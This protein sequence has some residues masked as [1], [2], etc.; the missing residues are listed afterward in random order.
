MMRKLLLSLAACMPV[1]TAFSQNGLWSTVSKN[2]LQTYLNGRAAAS[3]LPA[4][5]ELIK[6]NRSLLQQ[7]QQQAPL[8]K[9]GQ[10]SSLSPIQISLPLPVAGKYQSGAFTES[11]V[12]SDELAK[13]LPN[14]KT[15]EIKD[16]VTKRLQGRVSV[17]PQGVTGLIF[18]DKG[19]MYIHPVNPNFPDVHMAYYVKDIPVTQAMQCGV[20]EMLEGNA[21]GARMQSTLAGDCQLRNYRLA[22]AATGEYTTWA[23]GQTLAALYIATL[24]NDVR[25]IY[26]RELGITFTLITNNSLLYTNAATDPYATVSFPTGALLTTNHNTITTALGTGSFD[27]GFLLNNG[28]NGG[29]A[30]GS[31]ACVSAWKGMAGAGINF[32][33]GINPTPGPQGPLLVSTVAHEIA[34]QFS[35]MHTMAAT[36]GICGSQSFPATAYE[37]GGGSSL[38][39]YAGSC[40]GNSYQ[41]YNDMYFHNG[42][43]MQIMDYAVNS[44]TC[45]VTTPMSNTAPSVSVPAASYTIPASTPFILTA[46]GTDATNNTIYY[47]WE[48]MDAGVTGIWAPSDLNTAGPNF[49]SYPAT[50]D[51]T[52]FFPRLADVVAGV[53]PPYEVLPS[54]S[55]PMNFMV[56][57][58]DYSNG[59]GCTAQQSVA[60]NTD[61][62]GGPFSVTSQATATNW[63]ANGSNTATITWNVGV[64]NSAPINVSNVDVI[65]S[66][67]G[68]ATFTD[69]LATNTANDGT[70]TIVIPSLATGV[71]RI[72]IKSRNNIFY[73]VNA[74]NISITSICAANGSNITPDVAVTGPVGNSALNLTLSPVYGSP[75]SI[76]GTLT[77]SDPTG[78][79]VVENIT[80]NRCENFGSGNQYDT[81]RFTPNVSGNYTFTRTTGDQYCVVNLYSG[82]YTPGDGCSNYVT[83]TGRYD[84]DLMDLS[85]VNNFTVALSAGQYYTLVVSTFFE[86]YPMLPAPYSISVTGPG[87]LY[88]N[89]PNPGAGFN[90]TY[91]IV[92]NVTG[93]IKAFDASADLSNGTNYPYGGRYTIYGLSYSN[94]VSA[95]ALNAYTGGSFTALR[96]A[97]LN[98]PATLCGNFSAN[99]VQVTVTAVLSADP[100]KPASNVQNENNKTLSVYPN[101]VQSSLTLAYHANKKEVVSVRVVNT[102]GSLVYQGSFTAQKGNN[103]YTIP[104][105]ALAKGIYVVQLVSDAGNMVSRFMKD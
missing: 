37:P 59:G 76:G 105:G 75:I 10:R 53:S 17:T 12:L 38:M 66:S 101:P 20:K 8:I 36:N 58:H 74:A 34:H 91:V 35:A 23:G 83:S 6:L 47:S 50:T 41:F 25:T 39:A 32:G 21:T 2:S 78:E 56:M 87:T 22:V 4:G 14:F 3:P 90:Y 9:T 7:L 69:T 95:V 15:Y 33:T 80:Y 65:F 99:N 44:A 96:N 92:D 57:V 104:A 62:S 82:N 85:F 89:P 42:S 70:E 45:A 55:R 29:L 24:M 68:G 63:V 61:D 71:G 86:D 11:P 31:S 16:P 81:Y 43:I 27:I 48:Q 30:A 64:T 84:D 13:Q 26:E 60:V 88:S 93:L 54:V 49:R 94:A 18:T 103:Q 46:T 97:L 28:W 77:S 73:N 40:T 51:N 100:T 79:V 72:M 1:L 5:Y 19:A 102:L 52:R 98:N 67:D